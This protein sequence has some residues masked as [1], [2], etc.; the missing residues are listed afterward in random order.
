M[1]TLSLFLTYYHEVRFLRPSESGGEN[2]HNLFTTMERKDDGSINIIM[3]FRQED[4][5]AVCHTLKADYRFQSSVE[6]N[7]NRQC[8]Q[9]RS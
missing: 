9:N 4:K 2:D 5:R 8:H 6:K 3:M 7:N 1:S